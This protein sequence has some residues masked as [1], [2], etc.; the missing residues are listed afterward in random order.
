M[1]IKHKSI[2]ST[3]LAAVA[4][5]AFSLSAAPSQSCMPDANGW[6]QSAG[7]ATSQAQGCPVGQPAGSE[8]GHK[9]G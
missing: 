4:A 3:L 2:K 5:T 9:I 1:G 8:T 6:A 7:S